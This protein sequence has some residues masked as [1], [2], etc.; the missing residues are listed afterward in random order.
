MKNVYK[1]LVPTFKWNKHSW[2]VYMHGRIILN[3][4]SSRV[5]E[6]GLDSAGSWE[7]PVAGL[8]AHYN[9]LLDFIEDSWFIE[10]LLKKVVTM[11]SSTCKS[12]HMHLATF[13][14][15]HATAQSGEYRVES[16]EPISNRMTS[17]SGYWLQVITPYRLTPLLR[18]IC[19]H[20]ERVCPSLTAYA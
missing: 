5:Y 6:C 14:D 20:R 19:G 18:L 17:S 4:I 12:S 3:W 8:S 16:T 13:T 7:A 2:E 9:K 11:F 10:Q 1:I 15:C